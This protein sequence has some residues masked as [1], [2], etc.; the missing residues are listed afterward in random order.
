MSRVQLIVSWGGGY[1]VCR[2]RHGCLERL[3][4]TSRL[5]RQSSKNEWLI[6]EKR[7][8]TGSEQEYCSIPLPHHS[9][10]RTGL[11]P[12]ITSCCLRRCYECRDAITL[13]V[14]VRD[15]ESFEA[16]YEAEVLQLLQSLDFTGPIKEPIRVVQEGCLP[17]DPSM[18]GSSTPYTVSTVE[19]VL[20]LLKI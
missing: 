19:V 12:P 16:M 1:R 2:V 11:F 8:E 10:V 14:L 6:Q 18:L 9:D 15:V 17:F 13:F 3:V 4:F 20:D 5:H 7:R